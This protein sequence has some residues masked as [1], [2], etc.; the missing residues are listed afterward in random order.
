LSKPLSEKVR[1]Q[2]LAAVRAGEKRSALARRL[3]ISHTAVTRICREAQ[4][5]QLPMTPE[6][7]ATL[8]AATH[9]IRTNSAHRRATLSASFLEDAER[10]RSQLWQPATIGDF[11]GKEF[12]YHEHKLPEPDAKSKR[13]LMIAAAVAADKSMLLEKFDRDDTGAERVRG[14]IVD[15]IDRMQAEEALGG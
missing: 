2:V 4:I 12:E 5:V 7:A 13:D 1:R 3:G 8:A 10:L 6:R 15:L 14:A 11:G 9:A